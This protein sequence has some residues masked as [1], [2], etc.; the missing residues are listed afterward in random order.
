MTKKDEI[1]E[2]KSQF[3]DVLIVYQ[4]TQS[5]MAQINQQI[6]QKEQELRLTQDCIDGVD[7]KI[8]HKVL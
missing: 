2:L 7:A 4:T 1:K 5:T 3:Y 8:N 6:I